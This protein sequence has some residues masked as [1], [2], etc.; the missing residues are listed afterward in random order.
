MNEQRKYDIIF[1]DPPYGKGMEFT[2]IDEIVK[3]NLLKPDGVVIVENEQKDEM[4]KEL[5]ALI[6]T[7]TRKYGRTAIN[8]F[9]FRGEKY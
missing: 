2:A 5:S 9:K 1:L 3:L 7:D 8:F 4:P 6:K